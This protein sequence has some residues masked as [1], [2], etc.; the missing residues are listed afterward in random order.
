MKRRNFIASLVAVAVAPKAFLSARSQQFHGDGVSFKVI[1]SVDANGK[2]A[3]R[4]D[5]L[6]GFKTIRP[7]LATRIIGDDTLLEAART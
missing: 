7:E 1:R 3:N 6:Y 2:M 5:V 4:I